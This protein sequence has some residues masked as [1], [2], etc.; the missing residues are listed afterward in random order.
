[1][2]KFKAI[3]LILAIVTTLVFCVWSTVRIVKAVQFGLDCEAYLQRAANANTVDMAKE[4][5]VK[6]IDYIEKNNLTDEIIS[7]F[8]KNPANDLSFWYRNIKSAHDE[9]V[10][11]PEDS[12]PLEKTNVLMKLRESLTNN[13]SNGSTNIIV[14]QGI[15]VYPDNVM[16][17]WWGTLSCAALCVFWTLFIVS[18]DLEIKTVQTSVQVNTV[19]RKGK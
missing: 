6:A 9:L 2:K 15:T 19:K 11:L 13:D 8:L 4:E 17:F 12:T 18:L 16:Y 3:F 7:I 5:L 1:M 10:N 14:P